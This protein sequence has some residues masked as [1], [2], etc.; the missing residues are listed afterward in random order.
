MALSSSFLSNIKSTLKNEQSL[1][2][3][4]IVCLLASIA[5][6]SYHIHQMKSKKEDYATTNA[7]YVTYSGAADIAGGFP[8]TPQSM[9]V[10]LAQKSMGITNNPWIGASNIAMPSPVDN[11][12]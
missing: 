3:I 2:N 7:S 5:L 1:H 4:V 6:L 11:S 8:Y 12:I 10:Q 9:D